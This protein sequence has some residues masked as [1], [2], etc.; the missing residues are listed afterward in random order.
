MAKK[1]YK[2]EVIVGL[3]RQADV[4]HSQGMSNSAPLR[5]PSSFATRSIMH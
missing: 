3:L 5:R 1:R 2:P 4:L